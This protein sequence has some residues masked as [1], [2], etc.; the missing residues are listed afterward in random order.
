MPLAPFFSIVRR[1]CTYIVGLF[2]SPARP[3]RSFVRSFVGSHDG[4]ERGKMHVARADDDDGVHGRANARG[5]G[6]QN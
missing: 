3:V 5:N 4:G 1:Q 2:F 6:L